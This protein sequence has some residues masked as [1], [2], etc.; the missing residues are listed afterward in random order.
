[1]S[2]SLGDRLPL[3]VS[4]A[5]GPWALRQPWSALGSPSVAPGGRSG[6]QAPGVLWGVPFPV[7]TLIPGLTLARGRGAVPGPFPSGAQADHSCAEGAFP[8]LLGKVQP[9]RPSWTQALAGRAASGGPEPGPPRLPW[10]PDHTWSC[11]PRL[12]RPS[13][14]R[15]FGDPLEPPSLRAAPRPPG[16]PRQLSGSVFRNELHNLKL[17]IVLSRGLIIKCLFIPIIVRE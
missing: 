2:L 9:P 16:A 4:P 1:M 10:C 13:A 6:S 14:G 11:R 15:S 5:P 3:E 12:L 17:I 8:I 7:Q